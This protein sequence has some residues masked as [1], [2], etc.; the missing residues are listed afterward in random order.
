[1]RF[2]IIV[3]DANGEGTH[4]QKRLLFR[5]GACVVIEVLTRRGAHD[6]VEEGLRVGDDTGCSLLDCHF[7]DDGL[8][9][10]N[11]RKR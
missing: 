11:G 4:D 3:R 2:L 6:S 1:M 5:K 9:G 8:G 10:G 7:G